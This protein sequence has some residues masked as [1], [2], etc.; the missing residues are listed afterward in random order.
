MGL[1]D[2]VPLSPGSARSTLSAEDRARDKIKGTK[3]EK[4]TNSSKEQDGN[5][6]ECEVE[7]EVDIDK[8]TEIVKKCS[9][10]KPNLTVD[11]E[12]AANSGS[13]KKGKK[14]K[15]KAKAP[16]PVKVEDSS[17]VPA[18]GADEEELEPD[19]ERP[20]PS[21]FF[22]G[23]ES[24]EDKVEDKEEKPAKSRKKKSAAPAG[25]GWSY[26]SSCSATASC[27][28]GRWRSSVSSPELSLRSSG[29]AA[30]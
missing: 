16:K 9:K 22:S 6:E 29:S 27:A 13:K 2:L 21:V 30:A 20:V 28:P 15:Q 23:D 5:E 19:G 12:P 25:R 26:W 3:K 24:D 17:G 8:E 10:K 18:K 1:D 7:G 4:K 14:K 11:T